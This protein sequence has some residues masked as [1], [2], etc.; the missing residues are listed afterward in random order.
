MKCFSYALSQNKETPSGMK[1]DVGAKTPQAFGDHQHCDQR[2][3]KY[4]EDPSTYKHKSLPFGKDL[5]GASLQT[6]LDTMFEK[7]ATQHA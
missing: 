5:T 6:E 2:R 7:V 4:L 3:C 1:K